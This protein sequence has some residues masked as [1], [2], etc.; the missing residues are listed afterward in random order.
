MPAV[1][2]YAY[3]DHAGVELSPLYNRDEPT[4]ASYW[5]NRDPRMAMTILEPG[6]EWVGGNDGTPGDNVTA[7]PVFQLPRFASLKNNNRNGANSMTGFYFTKYNDPDVALNTNRDYK[8]IV[9]LRYAEILLIYA[10]AKFKLGQFQ[11][12]VA[13]ETINEIRERVGMHPMRLH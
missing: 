2:G 3:R 10:E 12:S 6:S 13:D 9:V 5:Q 1:R 11:Q 4:Y 8:D 7:T